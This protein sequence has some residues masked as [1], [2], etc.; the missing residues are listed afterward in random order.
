MFRIFQLTRPPFSVG[1]VPGDVN[2]DKAEGFYVFKWGAMIV[3]LF[4]PLPFFS[5]V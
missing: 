1:A 4:P 3:T 2:N 5:S